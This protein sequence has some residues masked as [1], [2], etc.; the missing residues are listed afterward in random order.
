MGVP[1][2]FPF[3]NVVLICCTISLQE[4]LR[5]AHCNKIQLLRICNGCVNT[6]SVT[7][8]FDSLV[9]PNSILAIAATTTQGLVKMKRVL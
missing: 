8:E 9:A 1:W 4:W 6:T 7:A 5:A 2:D 3:T